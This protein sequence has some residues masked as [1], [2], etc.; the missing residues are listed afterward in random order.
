MGGGPKTV[1]QMRQR[2]FWFY[3]QPELVGDREI[4]VDNF[5]G[6]GGASVGIQMA[7]GRSVD[8]ACNHDEFALAM[9]EVNHP[10]CLHHCESLW[11]IRPRN[12]TQGRQVGLA[13]FSPDCTHFS[14]AA[15]ARPLSDRVRG[16]AWIVIRWALDVRPRTLFLENVEEF[17]TW[18]PLTKTGRPHK[19]FAGR[20]FRSFTAML[21]TGVE[22]TDPALDEFMAAIADDPGDDHEIA[23]LNRK[24]RQ[25][26]IDGL[27][28]DVEWNE[29]VAS[30][31]GSPTTR[32]RLFLIAR[33]DG[34]P[35]V[36]P[37]ITHGSPD[38]IRAQLAEQFHSNL[39][40]WRTA[41]DII[42]WT[43]P[44]PSIFMTTQQ[45][46][47]YHRE[48]GI[49]TIRPLAAN[50]MKRIGNGMQRFVIEEREP[51]IVKCNHGGTWDFRGQGLREPLT[52]VTSKHGYGLVVPFVTSSAYSKT[53]GRGRYVY[54]MN[55][56]IRT[57]TSAND[58]VIVTPHVISYYGPRKN[59]FHRARQLTSPL[60][61]QTAE[62]RFALVAPWMVRNWGGMTGQDPRLPYPT[63][64]TKGCQ[65]T[66]G[67]SY[68]A[69][70]RGTCRHGQRVTVPLTTV[71]AGGNHIAEVRA[72]LREVGSTS[73]GHVRIHGVPYLIF[74]CGM[75][76]L[77][78]R[79]LFRAQGF[80]DDYNI[81][82]GP[83]GSRLAK[84]RQ[85]ALCGNSVC[86]QVARALVEANYITRRT[87]PGVV[88]STSGM[89]T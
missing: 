78:P 82:T 41:A 88:V 67:V 14:K 53:T 73:D 68:L 2:T 28:Y 39:S 47:E 70:L 11:K 4:V 19:R 32:K 56:P 26:L 51:F 31:H 83:N 71:T 8:V 38:V 36:W 29:I 15:G 9:H 54:G 24:Y 61:T 27:G 60:A 80:P 23:R 76:M 45:A 35:I 6:G 25:R 69:K 22:P 77:S 34:E 66:I 74:D 89:T 75:R 12:A 13:W 79:E 65:D 44:C 64:T 72:L 85:V 55:E 46:R 3:D 42:D 16:L 87:T 37:E 63:I 30:D 59:D 50:T 20:T 10:G 48:T 52:T 84:S 18:G 40:V 62:N 5:A 17:V 21:Q 49:R 43:L 58:K 1:E 7:L 81:E 86:P 33:C 57:I